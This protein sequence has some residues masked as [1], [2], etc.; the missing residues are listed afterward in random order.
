M[1]SHSEK[2]PSSEPAEPAGVAVNFEKLL[3]VCASL[4]QA[5]EVAAQAGMPP[6]AFTAAAWEAYMLAS[7]EVAERLAEMQF[8]AALEELRESGKMA[9]G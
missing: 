2:K 8:E 5:A 1:F 4:R 7:P 9:K 6:D 3:E